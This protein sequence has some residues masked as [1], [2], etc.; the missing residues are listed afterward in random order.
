MPPPDA[1]LPETRER[2]CPACRSERITPVVH[3][4]GVETVVKV[5]HRCEACGTAFWFVRERTF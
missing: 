3:V 5:E 4:I 2:R 1:P